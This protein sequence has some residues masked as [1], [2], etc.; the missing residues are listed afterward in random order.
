MKLF[1]PL[2]RVPG[3][4]LFSL[5]IGPGMQELATAPFPVINLGGQ[6][7]PNSLDDLAAAMMDMDVVVSMDTA[8]AHLA[9]ALGL[10]VWTLLCYAPDWRWLLDRSDSPWYPTMRLFRQN[11]LGAWADVLEHVAAELSLFSPGSQNR[12]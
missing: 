7:D 1:E 2:A 10:P 9:G 8:V 3:V 12:A 5:Q 6:F 4:R 11:K